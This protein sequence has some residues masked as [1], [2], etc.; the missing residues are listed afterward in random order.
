MKKLYEGFCKAEVAVCGV[1]FVFLIIFVFA[2]AILR[3]MRISLSWNIDLAM[4]LLAWT[5][6]LG[7]DIAWRSGQLIGID[8]VTRYLPKKIQKVILILVYALILCVTVV[9]CIYGARLAWVE[10]LRTYQS[11][12]I[13][14]SLVTLSLVVATFSMSISTVGKIVNCIRFFNKEEKGE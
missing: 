2:S 12:P 11:M 7:A 10:R 5:A 8:L 3:F 14:Y 4:L 6:F 13:P 9:I 1:G